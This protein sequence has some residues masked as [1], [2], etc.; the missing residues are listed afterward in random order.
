MNLPRRY[1][2]N[3]LVY[4]SAC[5]RNR[6][7]KDLSVITN[8]EKSLTMEHAENTQVNISSWKKQ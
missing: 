1:A 7:H 4:V 5:R 3:M 8:E 6:N 2:K